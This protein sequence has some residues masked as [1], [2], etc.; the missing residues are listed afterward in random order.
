MKR[1]AGV[2]DARKLVSESPRGRQEEKLRARIAADP[3]LAKR[4][5]GESVLSKDERMAIKTIR[6]MTKKTLEISRQVSD[7]A[8]VVF[9]VNR[10]M[11]LKQFESRL[12]ILKADP[13]KPTRSDYETIQADIKTLANEIETIRNWVSSYQEVLAEMQRLYAEFGPYLAAEKEAV[14][15]EI[16][17]LMRK[18]QQFYNQL[19][20]AELSLQGTGHAMAIPV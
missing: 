10:D 17:N 18:Q 5:E 9:D 4:F 6:E 8:D 13:T 14:Q 16:D 15:F 3:S 20:H 7:V 1:V 2:V 11:H 19:S 12:N